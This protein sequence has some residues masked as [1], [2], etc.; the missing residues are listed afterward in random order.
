MNHHEYE[1]SIHALHDAYTKQREE[2][3]RG[4]LAN[5]S[6]SEQLAI[7]KGDDITGNITDALAY[8]PYPT[9]LRAI[10][11]R[12]LSGGDITS[13]IT[14]ARRSGDNVP[15]DEARSLARHLLASDFDLSIETLDWCI[16]AN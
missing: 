7:L 1:S 11:D 15:S 2:Y 8:S 13:L 3:I 10:L 5:T 12:S 6:E 14:I 4:F 9:V 16:S